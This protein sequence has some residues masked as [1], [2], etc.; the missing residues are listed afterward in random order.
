[1]WKSKPHQ[2][3]FVG[4]QSA[5]LDKLNAAAIPRNT[6]RHNNHTT[7]LISLHGKAHSGLQNWR[8]SSTKA[9]SPQRSMSRQAHKYTGV[10]RLAKSVY[11]SPKNR[12]PY[13]I[14]STNLSSTICVCVRARCLCEYSVYCFGCAFS[15]ANFL[16]FGW[17]MG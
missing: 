5:S 8:E 10:R 2:F 11:V 12:S 3:G 1:M 17:T 16:T 13:K 9:G 6:R 15:Q 7:R 4:C 14:R